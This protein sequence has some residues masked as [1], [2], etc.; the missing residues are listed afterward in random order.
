M[1]LPS[2]E[3][4][5]FVKRCGKR[6]TEL[7]IEYCHFDSFAVFY[8]WIEWFPS[9]ANIT[10]T[11]CVWNVRTSQEA[12]ELGRSAE[13]PD[14]PPSLRTIAFSSPVYE[15]ENP[16]RM[17][18]LLALVIWTSQAPLVDLPALDIAY[19]FRFTREYQ[20]LAR[21]II[22]HLGSRLSRFHF[23]AKDNDEIMDGG[24]STYRRR[25]CF[26]ADEM[27]LRV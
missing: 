3:F 26:F 12:E 8:K 6:I 16:E 11:E 10:L 23:L 9:V 24:T 19:V 22:G 27:S 18:D 4:E 20:D 17:Y 1:M 5:T 2:P 15:W 21:D 13:A 14:V 7:T 25:Y